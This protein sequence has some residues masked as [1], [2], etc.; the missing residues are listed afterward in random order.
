MRLASPNSAILSAVI[1]NALII[2]AL[3]R[4]HCAASAIARG[5]RGPAA[6]ES[7]S[8]RAGRTDR[9]LHPAIKFIDL[10]LVAAHWT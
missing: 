3:I 9:A 4:W 1:F 2:V 10:L 8:L 5:C 7:A 6:P